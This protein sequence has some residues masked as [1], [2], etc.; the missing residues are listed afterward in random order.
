MQGTISFATGT[1][2]DTTITMKYDY[3]VARPTYQVKQALCLRYTWLAK[4]Y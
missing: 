3:K 2:R 1:G 4:T